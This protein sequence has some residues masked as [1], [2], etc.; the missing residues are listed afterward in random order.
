MKYYKQIIIFMIS[1]T[2]TIAIVKIAIIPN[3][4]PPICLPMDC[5]KILIG[6]IVTFILLFIILAL[7]LGLN[8]FLARKLIKH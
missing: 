2:E 8:Y 5:G 1:T 6:H 4:W 7:T 3:F